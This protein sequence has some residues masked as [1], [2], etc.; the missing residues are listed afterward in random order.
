MLNETELDLLDSVGE[1]LREGLAGLKRDFEGQLAAL[2]VELMQH[3]RGS[4]GEPGKDGKDGKD[5]VGLP[6]RDGEDGRSVTV[7]DLRPLVEAKCD[8]WALDFERRAQDLLQRAVERLPKAKDGLDGLGF[9][10]L[11]AE[12]DGERKLTLK[13]R[14]G[15]RLKEWTFHIPALIERGIFSPERAYEAGDGVTYAGS[16][17]IARTATQARPGVGNDDWRLAVKKG[18]DG[19]DGKDGKPGDKGEPGRAGRDLT[20]MGFD[21]SK[22]G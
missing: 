16:Y 6:G 12:H 7:E 14:R 5:A 13:F 20:Q 1:V 18:R 22:W 10:D 4:P 19:K 21:G 2:K 3:A 8:Q 17:W 15:D 11:E 9:D